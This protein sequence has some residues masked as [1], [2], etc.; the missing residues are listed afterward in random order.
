MVL[1]N[2][3]RLEVLKMCKKEITDMDEHNIRE[4]KQAILQSDVKLSYE[5]IELENEQKFWI[6]VNKA[7]AH[8]GLG[9]MDEYRNADARARKF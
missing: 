9:E 5:H 2:R 8:F 7:E 1:A 4:A 6:H 3:I